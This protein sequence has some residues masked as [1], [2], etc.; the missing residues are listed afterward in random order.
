MLNL[1]EY[2][3]TEVN[4]D[5][6]FRDENKLNT[7]IKRASQETVYGVKVY[8]GAELEERKKDDWKESKDIIRRLYPRW[9]K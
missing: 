1:A 4:E 8:S 9:R 5:K 3:T 7:A 6:I 2:N